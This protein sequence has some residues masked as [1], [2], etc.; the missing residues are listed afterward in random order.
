MKNLGTD[1]S[2]YLFP[3]A[4]WTSHPAAQ[5]AGADYPGLRPSGSW[6]LD[7]D[8]E[9]RGPDPDALGWRDRDT[10][11]NPTEMD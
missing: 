5:Y 10:A 3:S 11:C 4:T 9:L 6:R 2:V 1:N 8:G 7:P